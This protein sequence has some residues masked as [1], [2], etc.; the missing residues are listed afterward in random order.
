MLGHLL[1]PNPS[2]QHHHLLII[3]LH[4]RELDYLK[5]KT[6]CKLTSDFST[7]FIS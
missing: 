1:A 5:L 4:S 2:N 3:L 7:K 6:D